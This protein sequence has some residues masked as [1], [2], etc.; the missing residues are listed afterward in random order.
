MGVRWARSSGA[1]APR[2]MDRIGN[3]MLFGS[4]GR[5]GVLIFGIAFAVLLSTQQIAILLGVLQ[6]ATGLLQNIGVPDIWVV[7]RDTISV[8][9][10]REMHSRQLAR[11]RAVPG[12]QW[13]EPLISLAAIGEL[14][15]GG[16]YKM[17]IIGLSRSSKIGKPPVILEGQLANLELPDTVFMEVSG[18][19]HLPETRIGNFI[20]FQGRRARVVGT[21][22]AKTGLTGNPVFYTSLDNSR[23]FF[24]QV[25]NRL[26]MIMVKLENKDQMGRVCRAINGLPDITAL[27]SD[28]FRW[29]SMQ[30]ILFRT[31]IG[32]NF[33]ITALLGFI[34]G[35]V[36]ATTAF[37]QFTS[38][39]L[40]YFALLKA[41]GARDASLI[42]IVLLQSV[43]AGLIG[44]GIGIGLAGSITLI[45]M[46]L[47]SALTCR[48][49]WPLLVAGMVPML[50]C[51]G[52]GSFVNLR[53]VLRV[54][55][56]ILFQ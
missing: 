16:Y 38:D 1:F 3:R 27:R 29:K 41:V 6:Q 7:S 55:P 42:R 36:L 34:V 2:G 10:L 39:N 47:D 52:L 5:Y 33:G 44:Y 18:R 51:I 8:D 49:P 25:E 17:D 45:G 28:D 54:D 56:V 9:Y 23:R 11:V 48:F 30:F 53:R 35:L 12:V 22:R 50:L 4:R 21:C 19:R 26:S 14:P 40:P 20:H 13:A 37:Y 46:R 24:P 15:N 32:L 31:A 43:T